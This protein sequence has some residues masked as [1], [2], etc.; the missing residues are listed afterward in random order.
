MGWR[1]IA[2]AKRAAAKR[3]EHA[4][5]ARRYL[6]A[7]AAA[8][9]AIVAT[10]GARADDWRG[11]GGDWHEQGWNGG[12]RWGYPPPVAAYGPAPAYAPYGYGPPPVAPYGVIPYGYGYRYG[13]GDH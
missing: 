3:I 9:F 1:A 10:N 5:H 2:A 4:M 11:D 8:S 12:D 7:I 13:E 6:M